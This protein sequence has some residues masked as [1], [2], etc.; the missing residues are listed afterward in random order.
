MREGV[1]YESESAD[2][3][4]DWDHEDNAGQDEGGPSHQRPHPTQTRC[5]QAR[6]E[7]EVGDAFGRMRLKQLVEFMI[8]GC[9]RRV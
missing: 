8:S 4:T 7:E 6:L 3:P 2:S 9:Q 1:E 5:R